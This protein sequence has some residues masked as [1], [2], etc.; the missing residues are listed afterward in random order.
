M[1]GLGALRMRGPC[2]PSSLAPKTHRLRATAMFSS[3]TVFD[4]KS[5]V[6]PFPATARYTG[7]YDQRR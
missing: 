3:I 2:R 4:R 1:A 7:L 5:D 6:S